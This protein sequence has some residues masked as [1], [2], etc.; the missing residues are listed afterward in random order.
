VRSNYDTDLLRPLVEH[1]AR[2]AKKSY[3]GSMSE[4][5]VSMRVIADHARS[6]AFLISEGILPDRSG[7]E[8]VLR[9]VMRRAIRH[10]HRLGIAQPFLHEMAH[11]VV[12]LMGGHYRELVERKDLIASVTEQEEV[13][14]R[15]TIDRGLK[16]LDEEFGA[17]EGTGETMLS[18]DAAFRLYD[19]FGFP[20]DLTEVICNERGFAV[21]VPG[22]ENALDVARA[23]SEFVGR[24]A[25][26]PEVYRDALQKVPA[27]A[28]QFVGYEREKAGG[29]VIAILKNARLADAAG[30]GDEIEV[31]LD[32]TPLYGE[33]GGQ[34]GDRGSITS[35]SL[36]LEVR[37]T[38]K[39]LAGLVVH[40]AVVK[41]GTVRVGEKVTAEVDHGRRDAIRRSHSATHLM[42]Y[43]LR[44]VLGEQAQQKGSLV[45]PDRLRFDFTWGRALTAEEKAKVEDLVN[46]KILANA[47]VVTEVLPIDEAKK[48]GA[49]AIF[50]EKYGDVVRMLTMTQ[51]SIE[52][53]GGTHARATGDIGQLKI[54]SEGGVAAG[55]R[56]IEAV[57]GMR[58]L[59]HAR[60][61]EASVEKASAV[62]RAGGGDLIEKLEK[63]VAREKE[64][65]K[66]IAEL[67]RKVAVGGGGGEQALTSRAKEIGGVKVLGASVEG[68][69]PGAMRELAEQL[70]DKLG[71]SVVLL[72]SQAAGK[73]HLV[74]A[75]SKGLLPKL[76][77]GDLIKPIAQIVGGSGGGRP[78]MAQAG[79]TDTAKIGE[80]VSAIYGAVGAALG[81]TSAP[82]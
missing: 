66:K 50:E 19:T 45:E 2:I 68:G 46:E 31:V 7:R 43:A 5:D 30:E 48:R 72:A 34:M 36:T 53:C 9:R 57:T 61:L 65:D 62:V 54:L 4:D 63:L 49:T 70:R 69:D 38:Q 16:I 27:G 42:H 56:R 39:P 41:K 74:L 55:V 8:Y 28:V 77:A 10:G 52:L 60:A 81:V 26:T 51:D 73:V 75:V 24:D 15:Q 3:T 78:D 6:T 20:L 1:A 32:T 14:F 37:D 17:L 21:D 79:G 44:H 71:D 40:A 47:D 12:V 33:S 11:Q 80:A 35:G 29:T 18:G 64:L 13:R 58:A 59:A 82:S 22:Y 25:A 23:R 67:T 76:R